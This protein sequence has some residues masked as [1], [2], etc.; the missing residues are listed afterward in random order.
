MEIEAV[1]SLEK[2]TAADIR[3]RCGGGDRLHSRKWI[4]FGGRG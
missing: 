1:F 3:V 4:V 2:A